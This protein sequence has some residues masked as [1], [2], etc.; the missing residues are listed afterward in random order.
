MKLRSK[1]Q[2]LS[3]AFIVGLAVLALPQIAL[4]Q[5][6]PQAITAV[7]PMTRDAG[8]LKVLTAQGAGTVTTADQ[9]GYNVSA[10][11]CVFA[12]STFT[13]S[14]ST[15]FKIQNKDVASGLYYDLVTSS[16]ITSSTAANFLAAGKDTSTTANVS[17]GYPIARYWRVS[18]TVGGSSTPT[19]TA[20]I[21]CSVQ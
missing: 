19:V 5:G 1:F 3:L 18:A 17:I 6:Q 20:T 16:A 12:Q 13:G 15:T 8:A 11:T 2:A 4:P 7:T 10:V 14:P 9:S 21:G